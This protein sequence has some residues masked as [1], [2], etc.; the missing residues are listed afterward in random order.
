M[1]GTGYLMTQDKSQCFGCEACV[2]A[3]SVGAIKI[4]ADEEGFSYPE[5]DKKK[6]VNC[7]ECQSVCPASS[8]PE[9]HNEPIFTFGGYVKDPE[10]REESTSGGV[11][12][13]LVD[14][15]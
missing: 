12:S 11:F 3:C 4:V 13:A 5:I 1:I 7:G 9:R 15:C 2:Q 6:C 10:V 8:L 14:S